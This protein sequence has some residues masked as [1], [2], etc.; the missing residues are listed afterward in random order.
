M[1][2]PAPHGLLR[3]SG[4]DIAYTH[5][6]GACA[7]AP[8]LYFLPGFRSNMFGTKALFL[9]GLARSRRWGFLSLDYRGHGLSGGT[10]EQSH[11]VRW[12][13]DAI[14]VLCA[15]VPGPCVLVGSSMGAW[16]A[17]RVAMAQPEKVKAVVTVA[18]AADFTEDLLAPSLSSEQRAQIDRG[19]TVYLPSQYDDRPYPISA[20]LIRESRPALVLRKPID[21]DCPLHAIHGADDVDVPVL[22]SEKLVAN[23]I[24]DKAHLHIIPGGDHRLSRESDLQFLADIVTHCA[25]PELP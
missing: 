3:L 9:R 1:N 2:Q 20:L 17:V 12:S 15:T 18:A 6:S 13:D 7:D 23:W 16:I 19:E 22:Q 8:T 21:L 24:K 25:E 10:F 5:Q 11:M 4:V 14:A